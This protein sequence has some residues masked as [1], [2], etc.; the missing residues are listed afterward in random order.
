MQFSL[1]TIFSLAT[2]A[3]SGEACKCLSDQGNNMDATRACCREAG[4]TATSSDCPAGSIS[5]RMSTFAICCKEYG[6]RS[7]CRCP[8]GCAL[9]ELE[10]QHKADG[11]DAPSNDDALDYLHSYGG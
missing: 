1:A 11:K 2:F 6:D 10:A 5:E 4:G 8:F 9:K 7:D 3:L